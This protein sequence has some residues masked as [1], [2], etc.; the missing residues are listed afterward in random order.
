MKAELSTIKIEMSYEDGIRL[1][2]EIKSLI[3][4]LEKLSDHIGAGPDESD[5]R[6]E[7]P[8][9]NELLNVLNVH[10]KLPF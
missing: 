8:K 2:E 6:E 4:D 5:I 7:Y 1:K 10:D 9:V 3:L